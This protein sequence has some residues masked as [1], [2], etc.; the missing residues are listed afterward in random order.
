MERRLIYV[1]KGRIYDVNETRLVTTLSLSFSLS[2]SLSL[3]GILFRR[4]EL[5][6]AIR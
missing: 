4:F 5:T 2:L 1:G 6:E 3:R